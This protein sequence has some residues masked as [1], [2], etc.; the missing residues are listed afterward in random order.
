MLAFQRNDYNIAL[1]HKLLEH[2]IDPGMRAIQPE[3]LRPGWIR[4]QDQNALLNARV[5]QLA[6]G[7]ACTTASTTVFR[8]H[9]ITDKVRD[10]DNCAPGPVSINIIKKL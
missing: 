10:T 3:I 9:R 5:K 6:F 1:P 2:F 8:I 7:F 4:L